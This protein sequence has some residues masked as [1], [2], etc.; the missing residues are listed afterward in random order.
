MLSSEEREGR[1]GNSMPTDNTSSPV[2]SGLSLYQGLPL[3]FSHHSE[4]EGG[5][6]GVTMQIDSRG[7]PVLAV[8]QSL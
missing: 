2:A 4:R 1:R 6:E 8:T 5:G 3:F 7:L